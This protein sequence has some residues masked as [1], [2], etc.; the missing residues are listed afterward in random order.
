MTRG[1]TS[2]GE[3]EKG[4]CHEC[5]EAA[6]CRAEEVSERG[7][8]TTVG[9]SDSDRLVYD[10]FAGDDDPDTTHRR[11]A[12]VT[13]RKSH[14]C[15]LGSHSI[16]VGERAWM[17]RAIS[18]NRPVSC[19]VCFPCLDAAMREMGIVHRNPPTEEV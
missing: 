12:L 4:P 2:T 18:G 9:Y 5:P 6:L 10:P 3:C 7:E 11:F 16:A 8:M 15:V 17:E 14:P 1:G 13:T 19:Y